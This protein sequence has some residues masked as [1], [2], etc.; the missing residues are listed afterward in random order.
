MYF[1]GAIISI[2][3]GISAGYQNDKWLMC[4][5]FGVAAIFGIADVLSYIIKYIND[6]I[7][8]LAK[9]IMDKQNKKENNYGKEN[10]NIK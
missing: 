9:G 6:F 7:S 10:S 8:G 1:I 2:M 3:F 4:A 5:W